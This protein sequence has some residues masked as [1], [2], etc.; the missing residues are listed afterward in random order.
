MIRF[1]KKDGAIIFGVRVVLRASRSEIVG[2]HDG[3]LKSRIAAPP[4]EGA[5]NAELIKVLSKKFGV[6]K[7]HIEIVGGQISKQKQVRVSGTTRENLLELI[8]P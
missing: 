6:A 7:N 5:A 3:A 2:E 4:V 1:T 8:Q